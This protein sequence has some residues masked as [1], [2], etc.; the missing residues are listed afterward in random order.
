MLASI[1]TSTLLGVEGRA[2]LVEGHVAFG[3][4]EFKLVGLPDT[5]CREARDRVKAAFVS[6][7]LPW[8]KTRLTINLAPSDVRKAGSSFDL[9]IAIAVLVA[10]DTVKA[11]TVAGMGFVGEVGLDGSVRAVPGVV[12]LVAAIEAPVVIVPAECVNEAAVVPDRAVRGIDSLR[13]LVAALNGDGDWLY[14]RDIGAA[15]PVDYP[16]LCDVKAQPLARWALEVAAAGGHNILLVGPPGSG[17]TMLAR[18]LPG[19]LPDLDDETALAA[20]RIH[21]AVGMLSKTH[22]LITSAPFRAPHHTSSRVSISGGGSVTMRPGEVSLA[23]G[24]VLFLD[25]M[26]EFPRATLDTLRQPLEE[27]AIRISRAHTTVCLPARFQLIGA[28]NPCPCGEGLIPGQ[29]R[30]GYAARLR[31]MARLSGPLLDRFDLRVHVLRPDPERFFSSQRAEASSV[32]KDRV[33]G[34][35]ARAWNRGVR[36]NAE[37]S[38]S[39]LEAA[40]PLNTGAEAILKSKLSAGSITA[41]GLD[42]VRRVALT[43]A[44]LEASDNITEEHICSA[45]ELRPDFKLDEEAA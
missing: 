41:R 19:I 11:E 32:I 45:L 37:L 7:N 5:A 15:V 4:P 17:K 18:R 30:C 42:R 28:T 10:M 3:L 21:S 16:D 12:P 20:T 36:S 29:C 27:G 22:P 8:P 26:A 1:P 39:Q 14:P 34:A 2:V 44:D 35:R 24:G 25:E 40:C 38:T 33:M 43:L 6:S 31:Y 9:A 23:H 13:A